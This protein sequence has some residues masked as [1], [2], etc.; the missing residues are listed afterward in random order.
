MNSPQP[1]A[2]IGTNQRSNIERHAQTLLVSI[3]VGLV[4]W[5]GLTVTQ[6]REETIRL[7]ER[8]EYLAEQLGELRSRL[9]QG[10]SQSEISALRQNLTDHESRLRSLEKRGTAF[11]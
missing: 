2:P 4:G 6:G 5:V 7:Q 10:V 9:E 1:E 3:L 11:D 8:V